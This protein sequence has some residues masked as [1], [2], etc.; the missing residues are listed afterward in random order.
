[1]KSYKVVCRSERV[2]GNGLA[3]LC[4]QVIINR[5]KKVFTLDK[6]INPAQWNPV[7]S[8][9]RGNSGDTLKTNAWKAKGFK[10]RLWHG[11]C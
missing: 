6:K 3:P 5:K 4:L 10:F 1:M 9:V 8:R 2:R 11:V 7:T